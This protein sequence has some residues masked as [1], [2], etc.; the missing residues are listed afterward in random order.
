MYTIGSKGT[1]RLMNKLKVSVCGRTY[2][3]T[4]DNEPE[5]VVEI[6]E[7]LD[8]NI[9]A[10]VKQYPSL[11]I[12]SSAVFCALEAYEEKKKA[13]EGMD[14]IRGQVKEYLDEIGMLRDARDRAVMEAD[15]LRR[16]LDSLKGGSDSDSDKSEYYD[17]CAEQLVLENTITPAV[18]IPVVEQEQRNA[19]PPKM[20]RAARRK[21]ANSK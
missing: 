12:Q 4:T 21:K 2:S 7:K 5:F 10:L 13:E 17:D 20:N 9:N 11:G 8:K 6:A 3:I 14:N 19:A 1:A 18:T 16:E 15:K